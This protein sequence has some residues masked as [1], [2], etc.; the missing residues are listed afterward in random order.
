LFRPV[1]FKATAEDN[2]GVSLRLRDLTCIGGG[3]A[4]DDCGAFRFR[5]SVIV[6]YAEAGSVIEWKVIATDTSGNQSA[7][8]CSVAVVDDDDEGG[9]D[10]QDDE[11]DDHEP[12]RASRRW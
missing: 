5:D 4:P 10:E 2:C 11:Q 3:D 7:V 9:D 1:R 12:H 6:L 8:E